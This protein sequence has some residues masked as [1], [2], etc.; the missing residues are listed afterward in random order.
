MPSSKTLGARARLALILM[1][2]ASLAACATLEPRYPSRGGQASLPSGAGGE[3]KVGKPYQ[4]NGVWYVPREQPGYDE[5]GVA[6]WYGDEFHQKATANGETFDMNLAS[7]AH[8]TLPLPSM[9][10]VT[11][12]DNG[13]KL[14]V[15]VNDRGP[16][17]GD[18]IIDL[19]R[20]AARQLGYERA[21][22]ARV[23]V[24]YVGP[25][26]LLGPADGYRV[27]GGKPLPTRLAAAG[28]TS[29][30]ASAA[31]ASGA[32]DPVLELAA[33]TPAKAAPVA[34]TYAAAPVEAIAARPLAPIG[35]QGLAPVTGAE[36][37]S[38]PIPPPPGAAP[39]RAAVAT[40]SNLRVQAGAF[41]SQVNAQQAAARLSSAGPA[42]IEPLQRADGMTLYRVILP[43]PA[44]EAGAY[45]L[46]DRVAEAG[47][48]DA[49]VVRAF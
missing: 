36:I 14:V 47:F 7:A 46:R 12:L 43:A 10:E 29:G 13:R 23:R 20:E 18:R 34:A 25:A 15:R 5:I 38:T 30:A 28:V 2:G 4:V 31:V 21:G 32:A 48:A 8:T 27:A 44:D 37:L 6:S 22:L 16:F 42:S 49:R 26:P 11:N 9:V 19:S 33:G 24:R 3:R 1:A 39:L 35:S 41:S 45:A 17:V 40:S